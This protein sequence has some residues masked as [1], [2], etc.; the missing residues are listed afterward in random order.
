M[1]LSESVNQGV[2]PKLE[3]PLTILVLCTGNSARS[4]M[5]EALFDHLGKPWIRVVSAGSH[6][7]GRVNPFAIEQ[8]SAHLNDDGVAYRSKSWDQFAQAHSDR[9]IDVVLTV[10]SN[11]A[12]E[13]PCPV[14]PGEAR[15]VHWEFADPAA[16]S[17]NPE[18][19]R[20]AFSATFLEMRTRITSLMELPLE[21]LSKSQV[22][23]ALRALSE[24]GEQ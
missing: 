17:G 8:I 21:R 6:P 24:R 22:A 16:V 12:D 7:V 20:A 2:L 18:E 23:D 1:L 3:K 15:R 11:A 19:I 5:A 10:C 13:P 9:P 14:F 4:I